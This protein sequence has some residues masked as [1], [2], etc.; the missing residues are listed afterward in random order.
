LLYRTHRLATMHTSQ[1]DGRTD[2]T[3]LTVSTVGW[4]WNW[5]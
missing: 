1:T 5:D 2:T 3:V 4:K